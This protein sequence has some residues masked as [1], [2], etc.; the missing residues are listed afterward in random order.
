MYLEHASYCYPTHL[1]PLLDLA[2]TLLLLAL[3]AW[4]CRGGAAPR[5]VDRAWQLARRACRRSGRLVA[6]LLAVGVLASAAVELVLGPPV[7]RVVDEI[8]YLYAG[9]TFARGDLTNP[10]S[11]FE[12]HFEAVHVLSEPTV[13]SKYP[14]AQGLGLA[15]GFLVGRPS[16]ALWL[17][18]GLLTAAT[19]WLLSLRL[20]APWPLVGAL[21]MLFRVGLGSYWNQSYWGGSAAAVAGMLAL[22][23]AWLC[24]GF[25]RGSRRGRPSTAGPLALGVGLVV[26]AAS[27]PFEGL[28]FALPIAVYLASFLASNWLR[29]AA[30]RRTKH[31][32]SVILPLLAVLAAG[33]LALGAFNAAVTRDPLRMPHVE[34]SERVGIGDP[35]FLWQVEG[36]AMRAPVLGLE[37]TT[38]VLF[39]FVGLAGSLAAGFA[40]PVLRRDPALRLAAVAAAAALAGAFVTRPFY[41]HY[42]APLAGA[43]A[44]LA[45][46]GL[47]RLAVSLEAD[48]RAGRC[49]AVAFVA[50][51]LVYCLA[52]LPAHRPDA[53]SVVGLRETTRSWLLAEPGKDLVFLCNEPLQDE[54][55]VNSPDR[56]GAEILWAREL[57]DAENEALVAAFPHRRIWHLD[58]DVRQEGNR[59]TLRRGHHVGESEFSAP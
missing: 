47:R 9:E 57:T 46:V 10:S 45:F 43:L 19:A 55:M 11:P 21:A 3:L 18:T 30:R 16:A 14:P 31:L 28:L 44:F 8:S 24:I 33:G 48:G 56:G 20:P 51:Q 15:L 42:T 6:T 13:Q 1:V 5:W 22:G 27:R 54:W 52:Q 12:R 59:V 34:Y 36:G 58:L 23:G 53:D 40:G 35:H 32:A 2:L 50:A 17:M 49:L 29:A 38:F 37:R 7:P 41:V 26:L 25:G 39:F 4:I